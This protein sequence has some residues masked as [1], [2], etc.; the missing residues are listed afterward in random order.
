MPRLTQ[1]S[2]ITKRPLPGRVMQLVEPARKPP[3]VTLIPGDGIG[4]EVVD[5]AVRAIDATGVSIEWARV[6]LS[7]NTIT[8]AAG[9]ILPPVLESL[10]R[11]KLALKGPVT[12]P[13]RQGFQSVNLALRR[14]FGLYANYRPVRTI[15]SLHTRYSD[16]A[17]DL[18]IFLENTETLYSGIEYEVTDGVMESFEFAVQEARRKVTAIHKANIL[19]LSDGL[20]L[21][22]CRELAQEYPGRRALSW[23]MVR[24]ICLR[25]SCRV[26]VLPLRT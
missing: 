18:A 16:V 26:P 4:P 17:I 14:E 24:N 21:T 6:E 1:P 7:A 13:I 12:T 19:K 10:R 8:Q 3:L 5:A 20:F 25:R 9:L 23:R 22:C 11:S 2:K 15:P